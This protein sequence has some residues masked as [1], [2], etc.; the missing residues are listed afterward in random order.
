MAA[1]AL[2]KNLYTLWFNIKAIKK[3]TDEQLKARMKQNISL[4]FELLNE[5]DVPFTVQNQVIALAEFDMSFEDNIN[6][7]LGGN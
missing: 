1:E 6:T 7:I 3:E 2:K 5:Y 4:Q